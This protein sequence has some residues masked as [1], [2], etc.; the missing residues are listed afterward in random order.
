VPTGIPARDVTDLI[1]R[2]GNGPDRDQRF[3]AG[4]TAGRRSGWGNADDVFE[5]IYNDIARAWPDRDDIPAS[6]LVA[7]IRQL[8]AAS[9]ADVAAVFRRRYGLSV[10]ETSALRRRLADLMEYERQTTAELRRLLSEGDVA[11]KLEF[12]LEA[13][14][15]DR[16]V[17]P[18]E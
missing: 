3:A 5:V 13:R 4:L 18:F 7:G 17:M 12:W 16:P 10:D 9:A 2:R 11:A 8:P 6:A 15:G 14:E 1:G